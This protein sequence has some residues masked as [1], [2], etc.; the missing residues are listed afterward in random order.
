GAHIAIPNATIRAQQIFVVIVITSDLALELRTTARHVKYDEAA[1]NAST[2]AFRTSL[3]VFRGNSFKVESKWL[4]RIFHDF[5]A[6]HTRHSINRNE[7]EDDFALRCRAN[8]GK[9]SIHWPAFSA[10][11]LHDVE[12]PQKRD[13]VAIDIK[14]P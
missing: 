9:A 14:Y 2:V 1:C 10:R 3:Y 12:I 4:F 8:S 13:A 11:F 6:I 7:S 5:D